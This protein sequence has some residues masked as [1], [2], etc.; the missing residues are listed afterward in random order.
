VQMRGPTLDPYEPQMTDHGAPQLLAFFD[1]DR[2]VFDNFRAYRVMGRPNPKLFEALEKPSTPI[3]FEVPQVAV[4]RIS[5]S[6]VSSDGQEH[7]FALLLGGWDQLALEITRR[8]IPI[9]IR[10]GESIMVSLQNIP[11]KPSKGS[12]TVGEMREW[13]MS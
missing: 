7:P 4:D 5:R 2:A 1:S 12:F 9:A 11:Y 13:L 8:E 3:A 6:V 10:Q